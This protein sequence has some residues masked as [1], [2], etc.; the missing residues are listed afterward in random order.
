MIDS[1]AGKRGKVR[2]TRLGDA[3]PNAEDQVSFYGLIIDAGHPYKGQ[4]RYVCTL[5]VI[6]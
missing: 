6:D 5:R 2:Y 1:G 4:N 3:R